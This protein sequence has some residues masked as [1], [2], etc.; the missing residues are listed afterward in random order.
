M[1]VK[2]LKTC[3][4]HGSWWIVTVIIYWQVNTWAIFGVSL[5]HLHL[6]PQM[7]H[8]SP[9][10]PGS[11]CLICQGRRG[12]GR[13]YTHRPKQ[14]AFGWWWQTCWGSMSLKSLGSPLTLIQRNGPDWWWT[15]QLYK[16]DLHTLWPWTAS[17]QRPWGVHADFLHPLM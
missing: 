7:L 12:H 6:L 1:M 17:S 16:C 13:M 15:N 3:F 10:I 11:H 8:T 5:Q 2:V 9:R 4:L 14:D